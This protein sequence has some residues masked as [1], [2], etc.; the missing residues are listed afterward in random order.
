MSDEKK[1]EV[2][3]VHFGQYVENIDFH[4][5][6]I[7]INIHKIKAALKIQRL[8]QGDDVSTN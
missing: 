4:L 2:N 5:R 6:Q 3:Y 7:E 1:I 8:K